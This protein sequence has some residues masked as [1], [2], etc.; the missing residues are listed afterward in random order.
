MYPL[1]PPSL[2]PSLPPF[3]LLRPLT[4]VVPPL[5]AQPSP[6]RSNVLGLR[7]PCDRVTL[8]RNDGTEV[9]AIDQT[10]LTVSLY[11]LPPFLR[12][13]LSISPAPPVANASLP[14]LPLPRL[15]IIPDERYFVPDLSRVIP[16][17][18]AESYHRS[19]SAKSDDG[20]RRFVST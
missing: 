12:S 14:P 19:S 7:L 4:L 3:L 16:I 13:S 18:P 20:L 8:R 11:P 5:A 1:S 9:I 15:R 2:P 6:G 17:S 10:T